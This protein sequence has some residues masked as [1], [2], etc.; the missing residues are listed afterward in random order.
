MQSPLA[1]GRQARIRGPAHPNLE[2]EE[3]GRIHVTL[4]E[5][6]A[7]Q[8]SQASGRARPPELKAVGPKSLASSS[9]KCMPRIMIQRVVVGKRVILW[10]DGEDVEDEPAPQGNHELIHVGEPGQQ[11]R[12][13]EGVGA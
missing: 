5:S 1:G 9:P 10:G 4:H 13:D 12:H 6:L 11:H 3:A 2:A 8:E 7:Q